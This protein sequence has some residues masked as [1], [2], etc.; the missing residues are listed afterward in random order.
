M[1]VRV[2]EVR[3]AKSKRCYNLVLSGQKYLGSLDCGL[4][5]NIGKWIEA[6]IKPSNNPDFPAWIGKWVHIAE[7]NAAPQVPTPP[8]QATGNS[9]QSP[10][11]A[12]AAPYN[13]VPTTPY[14]YAEPNAMPWLPMASN[15]VAHAIAAGKIETPNQV[16][17]WVRAVQNSV[18]P[19]TD[20]SDI[21]Y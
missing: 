5:A 13:P 14:R 19:Q 12:A 9:P 20:D 18:Q 16:G 3:L 8:M 1:E 4:N 10:A 7:P 17:A 11:P 2:D 21:P 15:V 6:E